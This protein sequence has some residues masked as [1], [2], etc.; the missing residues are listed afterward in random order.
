MA[1]GV[2]NIPKRLY[3]QVGEKAEGDAFDRLGCLSLSDMRLFENDLEYI[4]KQDVIDHLKVTRGAMILDGYEEEDTC[5][6]FID[7]LINEYE[8]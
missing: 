1:E 2:T 3:V 6:K 8:Q 4:H 7:E 5:I